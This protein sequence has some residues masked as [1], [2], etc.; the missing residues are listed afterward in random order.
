ME[1]I[2]DRQFITMC[3][4]WGVDAAIKAL[5]RMGM[6]ATDDQ[7]ELARKKETEIQE[8][9][10]SVFNSIFRSKGDDDVS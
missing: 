8:R 4:I 2:G 9:W 10:N 6:V 7:I 1:K 3:S 5:K